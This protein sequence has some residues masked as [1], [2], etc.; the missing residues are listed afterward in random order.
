MVNRSTKTHPELAGEGIEYS[1]GHAKCY[2]QSV[3]LKEKM[4]K[5]NL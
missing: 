4:G 5:D 3:K 2:Y 1:W